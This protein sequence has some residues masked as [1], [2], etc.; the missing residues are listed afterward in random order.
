MPS[1]MSLALWVGTDFGCPGTALTRNLTLS[2]KTPIKAR[3]C[4]E[5]LRS[6]R[7]LSRQGFLPQ[8]VTFGIVR[9]HEPR[10][11]RANGTLVQRPVPGGRVLAADGD[12]QLR[13][14]VDRRSG[15]ALVPR[16]QPFFIEL[17]NSSLFLV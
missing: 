13:C 10:F 4:Y 14:P 3:G 11:G 6:P 12:R 17:K 2:R 16:S 9:N 15:C 8:N 7:S 1:F 5:V